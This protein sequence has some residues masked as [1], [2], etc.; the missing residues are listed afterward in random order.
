MCARYPYV[1]A[2]RSLARVWAV[3][4]PGVAAV[5]SFGQV[6]GREYERASARIKV[7]LSGVVHCNGM[8]CQDLVAV[9]MTDWEPIHVRLMQTASRKFAHHLRLRPTHDAALCEKS[10]SGAA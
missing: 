10:R 1:C 9:A 4:A 7:T 2:T 6:L 5:A 8:C 3:S